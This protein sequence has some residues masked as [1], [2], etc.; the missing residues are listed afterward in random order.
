MRV[1][2]AW[3][4]DWHDPLQVVG[5]IISLVVAIAFF[6]L[7]WWIGKI[8]KLWWLL[9]KIRERWRA[10]QASLPDP[11]TCEWLGCQDDAMR[12]AR[13]C[14]RHQHEAWVRHEDS[15]RRTR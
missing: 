5:F 7:M 13:H 11:G 2:T 1:L 9:G 14:S 12:Y 6:A 3:V 10:G 4:V 8:T 15:R